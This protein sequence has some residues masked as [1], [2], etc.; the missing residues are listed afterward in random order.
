VSGT[1]GA[2]PD[3]RAGDAA[4]DLGAADVGATR[5]G[6]RPDAEPDAAASDEA[7]CADAAR[8]ALAAR[9]AGLIGRASDPTRP[10]DPEVP[11]LRDALLVDLLAWQA[12]RV[13]PYGRLV[14]AR[15]AAAG[16]AA[17]PARVDD[18]ASMPA[19][20]TDVFRFARVAAHPPSEDVAVFRTSGTTHGERG[21][22]ALRTLALYDLAARAAADAALFPDLAPGAPR[23]RLVML[24]P[25]PDQAPDSSLSYMLGRFAVW[26]GRDVVWAIARDASG[27]LHLDAGALT[28]AL[29]AGC[30][31]GAAV[32]LLGTSFAF[33]YAEDA[34]GARRFAL[35][36]GSRLMQ[37]GGFKGRSREVP[38]DTLRAALAARYGVPEP[39]VVAEYGMTELSS[40]LYEDTLLRAVA[41]ARAGE[42]GGPS[43]MGA[44]WAAG[45]PGASGAPSATSARP[46]ADAPPRRLWVPPWVRAEVLDPE[47]LTPAPP[48]APGV[49][50]LDDPA[51]LDGVAAVLTSDLAVR[52]EHGLRL[53]GRSPG[54]T[55]R[56]C[57]LAIEEALG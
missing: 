40:Q 27:A 2:R 17:A 49:L 23:M 45:A 46:A 11:A 53:L 21:V 33:V 6:A 30:D 14:A 24:A 13:P 47:T 8:D 39:F 50:R 7:A 48:G 42:G 25:P 12:A 36:P 15:R 32:G 51:N 4:A 29:E 10:D 19:L 43:A 54:A 35:P 38:P 1:T 9:V 56:G 34:L 31:E 52:D 5:D 18:P 16:S 3:D 44:P 22:H 41:G 26:Y 57:S 28:D 55:P 37:T 20:P